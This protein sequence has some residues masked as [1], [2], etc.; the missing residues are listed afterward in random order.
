M[1]VRAR[2]VSDLFPT[3]QCRGPAFLM[4]CPMPS[5]TFVP[6]IDAVIRVL[7]QAALVAVAA[8][9]MEALRLTLLA[10]ELRGRSTRPIIS[11]TVN[12]KRTAD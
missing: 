4:E 11:S 7:E 6:A 3:F 12:T 10:S 8:D 5:P 2:I 1:Q 9:P